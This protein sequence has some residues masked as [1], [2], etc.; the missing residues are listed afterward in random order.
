MLPQKPARKP[1]HNTTTDAVAG[2]FQTK[3]DTI[4][5]LATGKGK[6]GF[7]SGVYKSRLTPWEEQAETAAGLEGTER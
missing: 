1:T 4:D 2:A 3:Q 7:S 5:D 6:E